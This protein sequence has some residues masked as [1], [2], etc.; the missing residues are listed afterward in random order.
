M[1]FPPQQ[2]H[3]TVDKGH[4]RIEER[5]IQ[6]LNV[7]PGEITFPF[8]NQIFCIH[9]TVTLIKN[10]KVSTE[11]VYGITSLTEQKAT[12]ARLLEYNRGHWVIENKAHYVRD[13]TLSEDN[14]RIRKGNGPRV[15]A[16][17]RNLAI[18]LLRMTG[19][20]NIAEAMKKFAHSRH[21]LMKFAG[22]KRNATQ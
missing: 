21:V 22:I 20:I 12:P 11:V 9:R 6:V 16:T 7:A 3:S 10:N 8:A 15:F 18:N 17:L 1:L 4:G 14:S 2:T 5:S 13:V 19:I